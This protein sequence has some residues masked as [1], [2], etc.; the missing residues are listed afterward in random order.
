MP[1]FPSFNTLPL[2][3]Q[4][5][6]QGRGAAAAVIGQTYNVQRMSGTTNVSISSTSPI[7]TNQ[8]AKITRTTSKVNVENQIFELIAFEFLLDNR[9]LQIGDL[10]TET[11]YEAE[12]LDV[13]T[14]A[15]I[16]PLKPTICMR[17]EQNVT[18]S[19]PTPQAGQAAQ[20][21]SQGGGTIV[22]SGW[23]GVWKE[24]DLIMTLTG[25]L[26]GFS[27]NQNSTPAQ[28]QVGLSPNS[29]VKDG[30][31]LGVPTEQYR[32]QF[33]IYC[34]MLPGEQLNELDRFNFGN[35]DR[36][37]TMKVY[38]SAQ[39]GLAGQIVLVEKLGGS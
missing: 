10:L 17:T 30:N 27:S 8:P 23:S 25:G 12:A 20:Q 29:R 16:R 38:T 32:D 35:S 36:Y 31:T 34:P 15:S 3:D 22:T 1:F 5:I 13:F 21:P 18:I 28:I 2:I 26:Y 24:D 33:V 7:Y 6:Q 11:G 19:R 14:V 37:E 4:A 39:T 9:L